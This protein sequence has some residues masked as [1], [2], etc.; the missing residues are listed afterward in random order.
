MI[1]SV[2]LILKVFVV[3]LLYLFVF[4]LFKHYQK[5]KMID[6]YEKQGIAIIPGSR[7]ILGILPDIMQYEKAAKDPNSNIRSPHHYLMSLYAKSIGKTNF[8]ASETPLLLVGWPFT[9]GIWMMDPEVIKEFFTIKNKLIEKTEEY[10]ILLQPLTG[11]GI[12][13]LPTSYPQYKPKRKHFA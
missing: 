9:F 8:D 7:R 10:K 5:L 1:S 4:L 12:I 6:F 11:E 2:L 3:L 13:F